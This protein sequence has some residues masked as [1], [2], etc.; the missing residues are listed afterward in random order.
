MAVEECLQWLVVIV[1]VRP[2]KAGCACRCVTR[3]L[4]CPQN[5]LKN[6]RLSIYFRAVGP[7]SSTTAQ[8]MSNAWRPGHRQGIWSSQV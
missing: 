1:G 6:T 5:L 8:I 3:Q 7:Y 4:N 2:T